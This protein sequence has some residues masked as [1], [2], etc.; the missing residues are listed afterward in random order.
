MDP[1]SKPVVKVVT[2]PI[3]KPDSVA[4]PQSYRRST[5]GVLPTIDDVDSTKTLTPTTSCLEK[6]D[7][8]DPCASSPFY[9]HPTTRYSFEVQKSEMKPIVS[10]EEIDLEC[11]VGKT[12]VECHN[13]PRKDCSVWPGKHTLMARKKQAK[14]RGVCNPMGSLTGR[15]KIFVKILIVLLIV[16]AAFG[17]GIGISRAVGAGMWKNTNEQRPIGDGHQ[18]R[19][20]V[21]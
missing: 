20:S 1:L 9:C 19:S 3:R 15:Q 12:S 4:Q 6:S 16:A 2:T 14:K 7:S 21:Q 13:G 17:I 5:E 8:N 18:K 10:T 11:G